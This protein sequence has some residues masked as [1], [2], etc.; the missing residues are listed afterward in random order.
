MVN[1]MT[2]MNEWKEICKEFCRK[3]NATLLF[4]NNGSFGMETADGNLHHIYV[5]ELVEIL[6]RGE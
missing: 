1:D 3:Q 4:V 6:K 5:D 2:M